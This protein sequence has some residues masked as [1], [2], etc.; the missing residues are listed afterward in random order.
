MQ[1]SVI[2]LGAGRPYQGDQ[3]SALRN[4][5]GHTRVID[6]L[7]HATDAVVETAHFVGGYQLE[8]IQERYPELRYWVNEDWQSTQSA[9]SFLQVDL[10]GQRNCLVSYSDVLFRRSLTTA[11][12]R[13]QADICVAVDTH[14]RTRFTGRTEADLQRCEKVSLHKNSITRLGADIP[15]ALAL[16]EFVGCVHF[17][18][19]A[20]DFLVENQATLRQQFQR[21]NL[22]D[23]V[24]MLRCNGMLVKAVDV[25][26]DWAE[27]NEPRDLAH[28]V[29]GT[30]AQTLRRLRRMVRCSRI[31]DQVSFT[32]AEWQ[33]DAR[34]ILTDVQTH[35]GGQ[36]LVIRSSALSEDGFNHSNAGAYTSLLN[37]DGSQPP[38]L[39]SAIE[40]VI[41][42]Y[43][44]AN[45]ENQVLVQPMLENVVASGVAFTRS[46]SSGAPYYQINY[47]DV[48]GSTESITSGTSD[49]HKTLVM[50]RNA[51]EAS[52]NIPDNLRALLP[53]LREIESLLGY[54]SLDVEFAI[55]ADAGL[56]ILQV[57]PIAVDHSRWDGGDVEIFAHLDIAREHF[58]AR[59]KPP[60]FVVGKRALFGIMPDWNPAEIIGTKPQP[61]ASSLYRHLIMDETWATQRAEYGYRDVRPS[62]LL[63]S[64]AGHPYVDIRASFNSFIPQCL[65]ERL[66]A[67]LA[68]FY[69]DWLERHPYL[70]DKVE[71]E[72]VP[73]CFALDFER[74]RQR[75]AEEGGFSCCEID[76]LRDSLR[77]ISINAIRRNGSDL[78]Q[79]DK[80]EQRFAH[81]R[82]R[83]MPALEKVRALLFDCRTYG[84]LP[85]AHLARSAFVAVTL[86]RS[87]VNRGV[88]SEAEME[89]FLST[90]RTV[91]H[92][93]THDA[94]RC[95]RGEMSWETFVDTYGHLRPG[96]YDINSPSYRADPERYLRPIV[97]SVATQHC[98]P[99]P[100]AGQ[101]WQLARPRFVA[102]LAE[103][104]IDYEADELELFLRQAIE[105]REYAKFAF[106]R[107]LSL[108]LDE[109][110][111]WAEPL[112]IPREKLAY[113]DID[114]LLALHDALPQA[115]ATSEYL[116]E[117]GRRNRALHQQQQM[118]ELPPLLCSSEDLNVFLYPATQPNFVG[119]GQIRAACVDLDEGDSEQD[120]TGKIALIPQA[121]PGYDWLFGRQIA[122]LITMY[123]GANSH[124]AIRAAEFGLP[125]ALGVGET[126]YRTLASARI[127]ELDASNR[128]I[129]VIQ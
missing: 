65:D 49:A 62:P 36:S 118:I 80:L 88:L 7:I 106:T 102:A 45:P 27:L 92:M 61:L 114:T 10:T 24:E 20:I 39:Q 85:F 33:A 14:W 13:S 96:T 26:G 15:L 30:K 107:N 75:L 56:H 128:M 69:L 87:A 67:R 41:A 123:G 59:Q 68:D 72:V 48:S 124:M 108:A 79:I 121:D 12:S 71:F 110:V 105:G 1:S 31:E 115:N 119:T 94:E 54:D 50:Q 74:W 97:D 47:D 120:L 21:G 70:H 111:G 89:D 90:I 51:D 125:A 109:L 122:G 126:R 57:R 6:W 8:S 81:L 23:L 16:A 86:L 82:G 4:A 11:L 25:Q 77:D 3:H 38:A 64:F 101:L 28:F 113:L 35:F 127:L 78:A 103:Q 19:K 98:V 18:P 5:S 117:L 58:N 40:H 53:A 52:V 63:I 17:G 60:P 95:A 43:P 93:L 83:E 73:T 100:S 116:R 9:Y 44:D 32:V 29:L 76:Q 129:R 104:G 42:S 46:L 84:T 99:T 22:S 91:S 37:I 112:G 34:K 2:F 55:T 66:A